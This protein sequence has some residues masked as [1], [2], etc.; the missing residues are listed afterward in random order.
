MILTFDFSTV[1]LTLVVTLVV[2][3]VHAIVT[4]AAGISVAGAE[5]PARAGLVRVAATMVDSM[6]QAVAI[7]PNA[8]ETIF[9]C[10]VPAT[11]GNAFTVVLPRISDDRS[12]F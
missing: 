9:A 10:F 4:A 11:V 12:T 5:A 3:N 8:M 7:V 6:A 1:S 2:V